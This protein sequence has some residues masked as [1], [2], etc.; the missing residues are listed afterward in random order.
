M[1]DLLDP[2]SNTLATTPE[3]R[4]QVGARFYKELYTPTPQH[5]QIA[6]FL[7]QALDESQRLSDDDTQSLTRPISL[8]EIMDVLD[9]S[10]REKAPG[11]DGFPFEIYHVI[12][13]HAPLVDLLLGIMNDALNFGI[14]PD[15]W[16]QTVMVLLYKKGEAS[17][18]ANWRPLSL[19]NTDAKVFTKILT[20][21]L[22]PLMDPLIS[23]GQTGFIKDRFIAYNGITLSL[24]RDVCTKNNPSHIAVLLD[25]E[26]VYDR[27]H[28]SR[29]C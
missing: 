17:R 5:P 15:S 22:R 12:L 20:N 28:P 16:L 10:P 25:Q 29:Y 18:L 23:H 8:L 7:L 13:S 2:V 26:K 11:K 19:I 27:V 3:Q 24:A 14:F 9:K 6:D 1:P 21:R 4:L